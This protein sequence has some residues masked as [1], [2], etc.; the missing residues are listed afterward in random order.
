[1]MIALALAAAPPPPASLPEVLS[2]PIDGYDLR[3]PYQLWRGWIEAQ[4]SQAIATVLAEPESL[5]GEEAFDEPIIQFDRYNDFGHFLTGEIR[6]YCR[7]SRT[8]Y[9]RPEGC[10]YRLRIVYVDHDAGS[11]TAPD[12]PVAR[13]M[14]ESFDA[15]TMVSHLRNLGVE[16]DTDWWRLDR[17][18][19]FSALPSPVPMLVQH[20]TVLRVDSRECTRMRQAI[21]Q[22][23]GRPLS[24]RVDLAAVGRDG[25]RRLIAPHA[26]WTVYTVRTVVRDGERTVSVQGDSEALEDLLEPVINA[27]WRCLRDRSDSAAHSDR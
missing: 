18:R 13:W 15:R 21:A 19:L 26:D 10:R 22:I 9:Y 2:Q 23:E 27:G 16:P 7:P 25:R 17:A 20:A 3:I 11:Y 8:I 12:N 4:K 24:W 1:M 6:A 14:R 5:D